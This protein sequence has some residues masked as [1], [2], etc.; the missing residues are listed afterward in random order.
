MTSKPAT[1]WGALYRFQILSP[2]GFLL[3][4]AAFALA[5]LASHA[6]GLRDYTS[7]VC[8]Q[9]PTGDPADLW[10]IHLGMAYVVF[11]CATVVLVPI[12]VLAAGV[13]AVL[14]LA[15]ARKRGG[16]ERKADAA[17]P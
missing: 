16:D 14:Q 10:S 13:L 17:A 2:R 12:L 6:A 15:L 3:C 4:A 11:Y 7:V 9:V 8:G 1:R 5:F